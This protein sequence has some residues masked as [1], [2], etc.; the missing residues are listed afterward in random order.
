MDDWR[1]NQHDDEQYFAW[2]GSAGGDTHYTWGAL[3]CLAP[4]EQ[5]IDVNPWEGLRFGALDATAS[6]NFRGEV[7][8]NHTYEV[9]VGPSRTA[10]TRDGS[11]RFEANAGVVVRNYQA[12]DSRLTFR[13]KSTRPV[14][15][16]TLEFHAG[17][18]DLKIDG[19]AAGRV[20]VQQGRTT[21]QLPPG[22]HTVE[23]AK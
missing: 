7:W 18:L 20:R 11:L 19:K 21:L 14:N 12:A 22:E 9:A 6:G 23:L 15:V 13:L 5:Y 2:G 4:L 1:T 10:L 3:L 17:D 8:E 16:S